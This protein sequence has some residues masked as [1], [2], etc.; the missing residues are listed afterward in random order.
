MKFKVGDRVRLRGTP[1][2]GTV[3][4]VE[5]SRGYE[6]TVDWE[7]DLFDR[8]AITQAECLIR[9]KPKRKPEIALSYEGAG[10]SIEVNVE[11]DCEKAL[12]LVSAGPKWNQA[13]G[14]V[15]AYLKAG[16]WVR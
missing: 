6:V 16:E 4:E 12:T 13:A 5:Q 3:T 14:R 8:G 10:A 9:L 1:V 15:I 2:K 7:P 11:V